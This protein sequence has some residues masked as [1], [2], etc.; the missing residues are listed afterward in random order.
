MIANLIASALTFRKCTTEKLLF[1]GLNL[2][3]LILTLFAL[4]SGLHEINPIMS[5]M[6]SNPYQMYLV[7]LALPLLFAWLLPGK[8]LI[9]SIALLAFVVGW[10]V[11]ELALF[12]F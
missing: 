5:S 12:L 10:D 8:L 7:K 2:L 11:K 9:P 1:V 6:Y 4:S 3:D